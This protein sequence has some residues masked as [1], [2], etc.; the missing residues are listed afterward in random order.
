MLTPTRLYSS[1]YPG[2]IVD[3]GNYRSL[4]SPLVKLRT[5]LSMLI[6]FFSLTRCIPR[7]LI[8]PPNDAR[9]RSRLLAPL[10]PPHATDPLSDRRNAIVNKL[11]NIS[12]SLPLS[13][14]YPSTF[15]K[16]ICL[17]FFFGLVFYY[18]KLILEK[19]G[20]ELPSPSCPHVYASFHSFNLSLKT[21]SSLLAH[22]TYGVD[23]P[24]YSRQLSKIFR[25]SRPKS[26]NDSYTSASTFDSS[27]DKSIICFR[28]KDKERS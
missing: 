15:G 9:R 21:F 4:L 13:N 10:L 1:S 26:S 20:E 27:V 6:H 14:Q 16:I 22:F 23:S 19:K 2:Q 5:A 28:N 24:L 7:Q 17:S 11:T 25:Q 3:N 8:N 12:S 18:G